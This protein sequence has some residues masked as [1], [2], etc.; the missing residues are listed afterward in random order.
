MIHDI[1]SLPKEKKENRKEPPRVVYEA[2]L[3]MTLE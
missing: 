3:L 2:H 1:E